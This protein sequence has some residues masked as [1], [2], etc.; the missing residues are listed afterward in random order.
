MECSY[1]R[2]MTQVGFALVFILRSQKEEFDL[3]SKNLTPQ[4]KWKN[5]NSAVRTSRHAIQTNTH[6]ISVTACNS[7]CP[8]VSGVLPYDVVLV[9]GVLVCFV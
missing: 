3:K 5:I 4:A 6:T 1:A 2:M 9:V 8:D 7:V